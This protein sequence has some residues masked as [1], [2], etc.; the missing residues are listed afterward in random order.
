[1]LNLIKAKQRYEQILKTIPTHLTSYING[2]PTT[3]SST[4]GYDLEDAA[5]GVKISTVVE[6]S[7]EN[8]H[9]AIDSA[10]DAQKEWAC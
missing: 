7:S 9:N 2:S 4:N 1:M 5:R 8:I 3:S 6:A 10:K